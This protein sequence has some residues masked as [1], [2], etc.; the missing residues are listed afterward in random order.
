MFNWVVPPPVPLIIFNFLI[1][2]AL[3]NSIYAPLPCTIPTLAVGLDPSYQYLI[4][5]VALVDSTCISTCVASVG[6]LANP[7]APVVTVKVSLPIHT[8]ELFPCLTSF[9][10]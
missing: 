2:S 9:S 5:S 10:K 7:K 1:F 8:G 4:A 3:V 6:I